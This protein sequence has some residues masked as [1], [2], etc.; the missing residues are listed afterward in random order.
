[1][2]QATDASGLAIRNRGI[3]RPASTSPQRRRM[4]QEIRH[5]AAAEAFVLW[6]QPRYSLID[7]ALRGAEAQIRWPHRG[8]IGT[9]ADFMPLVEECG[10]SDM[11]A[12][13][14]MTAA[15]HAARGWNSAAAPAPYVCLSVPG[16][17][18]EEGRLLDH[19]ADALTQTGLPPDG[20]HLALED[21]GLAQVGEDGLL[22]LCALADLGIGLSLEGFGADTANLLGLKQFPLTSVKLDRSL[23]RDLPHDK[24]AAVLARCAIACAH[25][26]GATAV[27]AG[28]ETEAQR[29]FLIAAHC[30][31]AQG[32]LFGRLVVAESFSALLH[33]A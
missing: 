21:S 6:L 9:Q 18:L 27:A 2:D 13:W 1:M 4:R 23:V 8:S 11:L 28:V 24:A 26:L 33:S 14:A 32:A 30:D 20:L 17:S 22:A 16:W 25:G 3:S 10:L 15:C 19:V 31:E 7:G 5:A 29:D 12:G